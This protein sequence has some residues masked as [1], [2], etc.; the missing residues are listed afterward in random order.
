MAAQVF[1]GI[2][3]AGEVHDIAGQELFDNGEALFKAR[4][5][6]ISQVSFVIPMTK[7]R[8]VLK[9][10]VI[11]TARMGK[12]IWRSLSDESLQEVFGE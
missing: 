7:W 3:L 2:V 5:T 12:T 11:V 6:Y 4:D 10:P 9:L 1:H 8:A